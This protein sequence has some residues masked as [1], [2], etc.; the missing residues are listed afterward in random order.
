[1]TKATIILTNSGCIQ[2]EAL[3]LGNLVL[4]MRNTKERLVALKSGTVHLECT[5][6]D[7]LVKEVSTLLD[8]PLEYEKMLHVVNPYGDCNAYSPIVSILNCE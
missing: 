6:Y 4:V 8:D 1:M 2:E 7:T 5:D 3:G